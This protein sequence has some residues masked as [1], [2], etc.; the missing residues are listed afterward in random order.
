MIELPLS[1]F[2][3]AIPLFQGIS[4]SAAIVFAV[5]EGR[6]PGRMFVDRA[7][8]PHSALLYCGGCIFLRD[9]R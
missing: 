5:L 2:S 9:W 8:A 7:E 4:H 3:L 1:Q 6:G